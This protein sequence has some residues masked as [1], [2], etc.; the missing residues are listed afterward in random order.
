MAV[1]ATLAP[2]QCQWIRVLAYLDDWLVIAELREQVELHP[3]TLV[4]HIKSLSC[5]VD[6]KKSCLTPAQCFQC[7]GLILDTVLNPV[8]IVPTKEGRIPAL[9]GTVSAGALCAFSLVPAVIGSDGIY[10]NCGASRTSVE[11]SVSALS[12]C[13]ASGHISLLP[14]IA[15]GISVMPKGVDSM[16][17]PAFVVARGSHGLGSVLHVDHNRCI[18]TG[19]GS[20][21]CGLLEKRDLVNSAKG[22]AYQL[23]RATDC[24]LA[25][26]HFLPML[27]GQNVLVMSDNRLAVAYI[28]RLWGMLV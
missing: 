19:M 22:A 10:E 8:F 23:P 16:E 5:I 26:R 12:D 21:L 25:L 7:L 27:E 14:L 1:E 13:Y 3:A 9:S 4:S 6:Y 24:L 20:A 15:Q 11:A 2:V 18:F 17:G 28:N